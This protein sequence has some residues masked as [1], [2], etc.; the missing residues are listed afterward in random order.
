MGNDMINKIQPDT[1]I[2]NLNNYEDQISDADLQFAEDLGVYAGVSFD[3][4]V[5][6]IGLLT[7]LTDPTNSPFLGSHED[8]FVVIS[9]S[10]NG[11][12][13]AYQIS[14]VNSS[15]EVTLR[16]SLAA[17]ETGLSYKIYKN[18]S[19]E[20]DVNYVLTQVA[21]IIGDTGAGEASL[22][23]P[24]VLLIHIQVPVKVTRE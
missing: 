18:P 17:A 15:S 9:G 16:T 10:S 7:K 19:L 22:K 6:T 20:D 1:Q 3:D 13:G 14:V 5:A 8:Y 2:D 21:N 12:D 23:V 4:G 11:N 24:E